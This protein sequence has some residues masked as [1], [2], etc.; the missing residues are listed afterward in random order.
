LALKVAVSRFGERFLVGQCRLVIF[1][2]A[3][4]LLTVPVSSHLY[5]VGTTDHKFAMTIVQ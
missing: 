2:F 5:G 3:V 1:L 4:L